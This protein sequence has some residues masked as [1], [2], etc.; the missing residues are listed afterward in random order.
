MGGVRRAEPNPHGVLPAA[1]ESVVV[2]DRA[3]P[4]DAI[5][6]VAG[7][8]G[9]D[10]AL[11]AAMPRSSPAAHGGRIIEVVGGVDNDAG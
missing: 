1:D 11:A 8:I 2:T 3:V 9:R 5:V 7:G 10:H 6:L 4:D